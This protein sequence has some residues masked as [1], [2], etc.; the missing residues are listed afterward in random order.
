MFEAV[1]TLYE[2]SAT[3]KGRLLQQEGHIGAPFLE[4]NITDTYIVTWEAPH[5][6]WKCFDLEDSGMAKLDC[7][8]KNKQTR[9]RNHDAAS[10]ITA[11]T[12]LKEHTF[13]EKHAFCAAMLASTIFPKFV[14]VVDLWT[15]RPTQEEGDDDAKASG[16][17]DNSAALSMVIAFS[18]ELVKIKTIPLATS[19]GTGTE[20]VIEANDTYASLI[21]QDPVSGTKDRAKLGLKVN[22]EIAK[23]LAS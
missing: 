20:T 3:V 9:K 8:K 19:S 12:W 23:K 10:T 21:E 13:M 5:G 15:R 16:G 4:A 6:R 11:E 1:E 14:V 7:S 18:P 17:T 22:T 2:K